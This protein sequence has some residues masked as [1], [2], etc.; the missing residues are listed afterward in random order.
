[1]DTSTERE[2]SRFFGSAAGWIFCAFAVIAAFFLIAEHRA[3]L[4]FILPYV[5]FAL[6][7]LCLVL[8]ASMHGRGHGRPPAGDASTDDAP[9]REHDHTHPHS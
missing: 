6:L 1:M 5:P 4:G 9:R 7:G 8:H 3:H 2:P